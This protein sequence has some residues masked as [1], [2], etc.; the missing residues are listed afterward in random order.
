MEWS[1]RA[2][3]GQDHVDGIENK[4]KRH[5]QLPRNQLGGYYYNPGSEI[6]GSVGSGFIEDQGG[7]V[8]AQ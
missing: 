5:E 1:W 8:N 6:D 3:C 2:G 7:K 4:L